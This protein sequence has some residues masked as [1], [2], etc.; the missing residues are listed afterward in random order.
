MRYALI[1]NST[2]TAVQRLLGGIPI[3]NKHVI[4][5]DILA[6]ENLIQAILFYDKILSLDDY[7]EQY[8]QSRKEIFNTIMPI[9]PS[10]VGY[11]E[12][13]GEAKKIT[14]DIV[15]CVEGGRFTDEDFAP[16]FQSLRM[17]VIFT[18]DLSSSNY[19]LTLKML[20]DVGGLDIPKYSKLSTMIFSEL[21]DKSSSKEIERKQPLL[22]D[23]NGRPISSTYTITDKEGHEQDTGISRQVETFFAGLNWLA[24]RTVL[25]TL[26]AKEIKVDLFLH[27]IRNAFQINL[28]SK[29]S[30][31]HQSIFE[32][33][34]KA[35]NGL[36]SSTIN[37][38]LSST[39]PIILKQILPMFTVWLAEK[40]GDPHKFIETAYEIRNEKPFVEARAQLI[41][42]E[43]LIESNN[44]AFVKEA[45]KLVLDVIKQMRRIC[46]RYGI[47][48]P[49]GI[50]VSPIINVWNV[51]TLMSG[52]PK[53]PK[54]SL[55][56]KA[57]D[58]LRDYI[59]KKG[60][61]AVYKSLVENLS[62]I[63]KLGKYHDII[64]SKI[65]LED[66]AD[67]YDA[68]TEKSQYTKY[69]SSWKIPM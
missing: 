35:M 15:P 55:D 58:F 21:I 45:N 19:Y 47:E 53:V 33:I 13:I 44:S 40:T 62:H 27:P 25:Y 54:L 4:D 26:V 23:S 1:D 11:K 22:F 48:T 39:Q 64:S 38:V 3:K 30:Q 7:K 61:A 14:E 5:G 12:L 31:G 34:M 68:K 29:I 51:T 50:P 43:N 66:Q 57:L 63:E 36:A 28:L 46:V 41:E 18:W 6:L 9:V 10:E 49:Q 67:Y 20:E 56:I 69:K 42:L 2:L 59:P 16:F 32:P 65:I 17:N 52:L 8:R 37:S 60:F 24:F